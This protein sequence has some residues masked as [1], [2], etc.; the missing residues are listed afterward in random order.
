VI[1]KLPSLI[2]TLMVSGSPDN[3]NE[4]VTTSCPRSTTNKSGDFELTGK[5]IMGEP[6]SSTKDNFKGS[7][8]I[9]N[10]QYEIVSR[11]CN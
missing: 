11:L 10:V 2:T 5:R 4:F 9:C 7:S 3:L 8:R 6:A 1:K